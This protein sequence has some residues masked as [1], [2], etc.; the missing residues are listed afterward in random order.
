MQLTEKITT[1]VAERTAAP[2]AADTPFTDLDLDSLVL[3]ELAT[4]LKRDHGVNLTEDDLLV[5]GTPERV[6]ALVGDR[7]PV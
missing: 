1:F 7:A 6:A 4:Q 2:V 5:A 3:L